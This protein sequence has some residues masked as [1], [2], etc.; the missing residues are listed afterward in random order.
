MRPDSIAQPSSV[1]Y[2]DHTD[3]KSKAGT[4]SHGG[5]GVGVEVG[6]GVGVEVGVGGGVMVGIGV[7]VEDGGRVIVGVGVGDGGIV[8]VAVGGIVVGTMTAT[9]VGVGVVSADTRTLLAAIPKQIKLNTNPIT[10]PP[11]F[12][13]RCRSNAFSRAVCSA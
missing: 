1:L 5:I 7:E 4:I 10:P 8:G 12:N 3:E 13:Q 9:L 6:V 2:L 11:I